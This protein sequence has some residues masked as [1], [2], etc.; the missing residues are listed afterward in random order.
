MSGD[1]GERG[2]REE[3]QGEAEAK[4]GEDRYDVDRIAG[5]READGGA[6]EGR[7]AWRREQRCHRAGGKI[8]GEPRTPARGG[9]IA[10]P[11]GQRDLEEAGEIRGEDGD[12]R[13]HGDEKDRLLE[14]HAPAHRKPGGLQTQR[15]RRKRQERGDDAASG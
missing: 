4:R 3:R 1:R 13:R 7:R 10:E 9:E 6:E 12:E 8:A 11:T 2:D 5:E 14:L 15:R